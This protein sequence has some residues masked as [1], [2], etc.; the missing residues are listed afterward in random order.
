MPLKCCAG[1]V[2]LF[3]FALVPGLFKME[4]ILPMCIG[5]TRAVITKYYKLASLNEV[6]C[7]DKQNLQLWKL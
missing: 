3:S 4:K 6:Y 7:V 5:F 1:Q 2:L